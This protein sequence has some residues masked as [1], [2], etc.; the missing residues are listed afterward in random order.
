[1]TNTFVELSAATGCQFDNET[2]SIIFTVEPSLFRRQLALKLKNNSNQPDI[3]TQF[4]DNLQKYTEEVNCLRQCLVSARVSN[5]LSHTHKSVSVDSLFKT[6][7]AIDVLQPNIITNLLERLPEFYDELEQNNSSSCT[8]RLILHQL[9]WLDYIVEPQQ[10]TGVLIEIIQVT[11]IEIQ[12]EIITSLPDILNDTEHKPMV[13]FLKEWMQ[14]N[15]DLTVPILDAL[16]NLNLH[17]EQ[18]DDVRSMVLD[19]LQS[20][21]LDDLAIM[22]KFLLQTVTPQTIDTT[23]L[24]IRENLDLKSLGRIQQSDTQLRTQQTPQS[25]T[26]LILESIK[27]GLQ[28]HKFVCDAWVRSLIALESQKAHK[29]I[30]VLVL[31]IL[32]SMASMK[33][34]LNKQLERKSLLVRL[35]RS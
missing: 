14:E 15:P 20:A 17:S 13:V 21:D 6:L 34:K 32:Y 19:R 12:H 23:I 5:D 3:L 16:S 9:R 28:F 24:D 25:P 8:A 30:D 10:L 11:P 27:L 29:M 7:L 2:N 26:A 18:L 1:M 31:F 35:H 33:K 22:I 4:I